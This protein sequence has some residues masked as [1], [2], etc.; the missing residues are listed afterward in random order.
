M[1]NDTSDPHAD[2]VSENITKLK[3]DPG[4]MKMVETVRRLNKYDDFSSDFLDQF[5]DK[6]PRKFALQI[7]PNVI[8][9]AVIDW[10][11]VG[12]K[13]F[14]ALTLKPKPE[15][16]TEDEYF[17]LVKEYFE[18]LSAK[19]AM[20]AMLPSFSAMWHMMEYMPRKV[21]DAIAHLVLEGRQKVVIKQQQ[22][23]G[24]SVPSPAKFADQLAK[25]ERDAIKKRLP[26][27]QPTKTKP[28]WQNENNLRRFAEKVNARHLL[29]QCMKNI[30]DRAD[31]LDEWVEDLLHDKDF[32]LL[33]K[34]VPDEG[35][36]WAIRQ[37]G[38]DKVSPRDKEPVLIACEISRQE[39][40]FPFQEIQTLRGYYLS[41]L[42]LL[43][44]NRNKQ[45]PLSAIGLLSAPSIT[46]ADSADSTP[47]ALEADPADSQ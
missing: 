3:S 38:D 30:Y 47:S 19:E 27:V 20:D 39:L 16:F 28:A 31:F 2:L 33:S 13:L 9:Y 29:C 40:D 36:K 43:R 26:K 23:L 35:I 45:K 11:A 1:P 6:L 32:T 17:R 15:Q 44:A 25:I 10:R 22:E 14:H 41:G 5:P 4:F 24:R 7:G 46:Q 12:G 34:D 42:K 8:G 37:I 18:S 21:N